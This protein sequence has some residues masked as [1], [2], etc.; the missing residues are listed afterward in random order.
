MSADSED[1]G[2]GEGSRFAAHLDRG[3]SQLE[4][5]DS[6]A[7]RAAAEEARQLRP[8]DP[9]A[10]LLL[11][12]IARAD[13]LP[14]ESLRWY[15]QATEVA[16]QDPEGFAAAAA[17]C[18]GDL[19]APL[20]AL[21]YCEDGLEGHAGGPFERLEL[22]LLAA[23]AE[24]DLAR[25]AAA[26]SRLQGL[27]EAEVLAAA[28][29]MPAVD[30]PVEPAPDAD[31]SE[32]EAVAAL[33]FDLDGE[34]L[35]PDDQADILDRAFGLAVRLVQLHMELGSLDAASALARILVG[36]YAEEPDGWYL[37]S[38]IEILSG[39][40]A[41]AAAAAIRCLDLEIRLSN[42]DDT[43]PPEALLQAALLHQLRA[44]PVLRLRALI[45]RP[46]GFHLEVVAHPPREYVLEGMDPRTP[47]L[48]TM[49]QAGLAD[50]SKAVPTGLI[51]YRCNLRYLGQTPEEIA[52]QLRLIAF[53]ELARALRLS[54]TEMASLGLEAAVEQDPPPP[55]GKGK[56]GK[57]KP[58][59]GKPGPAKAT[60][61][62]SA[63]KRQQD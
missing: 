63:T 32:A 24:L 54:S 17:L 55:A 1:R 28:L 25:P 9:E 30:E 53:D 43:L 21:Q 10:L 58:G 22:A 29:R 8:R 44:A 6:R 27:P 18:L 57:G 26:R 56:P 42:G 47:A 16:P 15:H 59:K 12:A 60:K 35:D 14:D 31:P 50:E 61:P 11:G 36:H 34:P 48:V 19:G 4:R 52:E 33:Y 37:L 62:R 46:E 13:R 23:D 5:G 39:D 3:W 49:S 45:E 38:E 20:K 41:R 2:W 7:A 51:V 40:P